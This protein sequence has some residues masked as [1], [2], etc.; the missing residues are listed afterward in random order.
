MSSVTVSRGGWHIIIIIIGFTVVCVCEREWWREERTDGRRR[1]AFLLYTHARAKKINNVLY[2]S[3]P[4][5]MPSLTLYTMT[6]YI[7]CVWFWEVFGF[8]F[9]FEKT[10]TRPILFNLFIFFFLS[11]LLRSSVNLLLTVNGGARW[12]FGADFKN[13]TRNDDFSN[14]VRFCSTCSLLSAVAACCW[15]AREVWVTKKINKYI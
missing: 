4:L 3:F 13:R 5:L 8:F 14:I 15:C 6:T 12:V 1:G 10:P 11:F 2:F 9:F 7:V